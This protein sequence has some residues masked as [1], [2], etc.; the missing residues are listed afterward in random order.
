[1]STDWLQRWNER[2]SE[3]SYAYGT[4]PNEYLKSAL[5]RLAPGKIL[6]G[7][8]GEGRNAVHAAISGWQVSAFDISIEGKNKAMKLAS[9]HGVSIDYQVG[10]LPELSFEDESF[11]AIGLIYAHFPPDIKAAYHKILDRCLKPGGHIIFEAFG[12]QHLAYKQRDPKIGGPGDLDTL[13]SVKEIKSYFPNYEILELIEQEV[14]LHEGLYHNGIG[15]V[16]RFLGR[17]PI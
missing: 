6:F 13:Y 1:M 17:K 5:A 4:E 14:E 11:D 10:L 12:K 7:A 8:E 3:E 9:E 16:V 15:S 2:Y